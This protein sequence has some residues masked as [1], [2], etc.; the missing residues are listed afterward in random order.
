MSPARKATFIALPA[1]LL[2]GLVT[3]WLISSNLGDAGET[4]P[5]EKVSV[6]E[7]D[8]TEDVCAN[9]VIGLPDELDGRQK[10]AVT[11]H[12]GSLAWGDPPIT[13]V[14]GVPKPDDI[15]TATNLTAVNGVTWMVEQ[16]T[17]TSDYGLPGSNVV[18]TAV[19]REVYVSVA[20]PSDASGS[21]II[22]PISKV[23]GE[24]LKGTGA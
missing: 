11:G 6:Q 18:W 8:G 5:L 10:R 23:L 22:S 1:A 21:A 7:A 16:D 19:D 12:P 20:V 3:A 9:V 2:A 4:G 13:L 17:D 24:R 14:C 15:E